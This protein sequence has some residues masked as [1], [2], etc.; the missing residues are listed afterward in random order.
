MENLRS[1]HRQLR[2]SQDAGKLVGCGSP[3]R[4]DGRVGL[5]VRNGNFFITGNEVLAEKTR[6][7]RAYSSPIARC[8][9]NFFG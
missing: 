2:P 1:F 7:G 4:G 6:R 8:R 9:K 5:F 3:R